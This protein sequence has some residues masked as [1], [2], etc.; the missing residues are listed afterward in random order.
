MSETEIVAEADAVVVGGGVSGSSTA[1]YL[2]KAGKKVIVVEKGLIAGEA[3][4]RNG[5]FTMQMGRAPR[6]MSLAQLAVRLWPTIEQETGHPT[7]WRRSGGLC[8]ALND[9]EWQVMNE[10]LAPQR[11]G[12]LECEIVAAATCLEMVPAL[13]NKVIGGFYVPGDGNANPVIA[14]KSIARGARD[15]GAEIW[16]ET[17]ARGITVENGRV[18]AIERRAMSPTLDAVAS[19]RRGS[20][21]AAVRGRASWASG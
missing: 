8:V 6:L 7:E 1:Y 12:G 10:S 21:S 9:Y 3:S 4:G 17:E 2:S 16:E 19:A 15:R 13:S 14:T 11:A 20:R 5:G 18:T